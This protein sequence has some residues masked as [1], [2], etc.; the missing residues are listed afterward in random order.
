[1]GVKDWREDW[2]SGSEVAGRFSLEKGLS[3]GESKLKVEECQD[4]VGAK[5]L[6]RRRT[7]SGFGV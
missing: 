6:K 1:M 3:A 5:S 7:G 2:G 4:G